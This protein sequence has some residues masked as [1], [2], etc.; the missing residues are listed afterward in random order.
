[1][2]IQYDH[3]KIKVFS[4]AR[5]RLAQLCTKLDLDVR[6][7]VS[8]RYYR[9]LITALREE[10]LAY[11]D[12]AAAYK[13]IPMP[14]QNPITPRAHQLK[15]LAAWRNNGFEGVVCLPTG[16][17]KTIL[18]ILAMAELGR[19][20]LVVVP[21]L[22]L[23]RQWRETLRRYFLCEI[24]QLGGGEQTPGAIVVAT[25]D[26]ALIYANKIG[27][28]FG[29]VVFDECHHLP[30]ASYQAIGEALVAPF[31]LGLSAT[32][33]REDG[34][35]Y[36]LDELIGAVVYQESVIN[37]SDADVLAKYETKIIPVELTE[38]ER[39]D[40][41][42]MRGIY[43]GF[44]QLNKI[45]PS[46]NWQDFLRRAYALPG[47]RAA[48]TAYRRQKQ[49]Y[50]NAQSKLV[51]AWE[52]VSKHRDDRVIIFT[53][54]NMQAYDLGRQ[55]IAPVISHQTKAKERDLLL[56]NFDE[57]TLKVMVTSKVL[58]EGVDVPEA[59]V[60]IVLSG[61]STVR[62]HVQRL[63]RILRHRPGKASVL[64][65]LLAKDTAEMNVGKKRRRHDAYR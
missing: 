18:A 33:E 46:G 58:N 62:E 28:L 52:L 30:A 41:D 13:K 21:T 36:L 27:N 29:F 16:A 63:G 54:N 43:L 22:D 5:D 9:P 26:S 56:K 35:E 50:Q 20:T 51:T 6:A 31:R 8:A 3:G 32:L 64:Y 4:E 1:M 17:G 55:F 40:Y 53:D 23:V 14:L 44:L 19:S 45:K 11:A 57:G 47:G 59:N 42:K 48:I 12:D 10:K 49:I 61:S 65:E 39:A 38:S 34:A 7:G 25:Y 15:A 24:G 60:A 37:L 2:R